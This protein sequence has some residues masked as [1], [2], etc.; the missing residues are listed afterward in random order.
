MGE[1]VKKRFEVYKGLKYKRI[2]NRSN[3]ILF[4]RTCISSKLYCSAI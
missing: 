2:D 3:Y 1:R 4:A